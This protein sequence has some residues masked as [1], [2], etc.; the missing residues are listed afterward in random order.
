MCFM[1]EGYIRHLKL[2]PCELRLKK[3]S[4]R[5]KNGMYHGKDGGDSPTFREVKSEL[6]KHS[7]II[8]DEG[9]PDKNRT[10]IAQ[11]LKL[12]NPQNSHGTH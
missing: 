9:I 5:R 12:E 11:E 1:K 4:G 3:T 10:S 6:S 7:Y 8:I 2:Y